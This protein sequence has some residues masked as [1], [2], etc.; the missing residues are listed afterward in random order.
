[1][2]SVIKPPPPRRAPL[3][4]A[5]GRSKTFLESSPSVHFLSFCRSSRPCLIGYGVVHLM[6]AAADALLQATRRS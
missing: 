4:V 2:S 5:R 3:A 1:M 6:A